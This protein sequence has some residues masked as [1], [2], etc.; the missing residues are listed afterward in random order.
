MV[1]GNI[2]R[3]SCTKRHKS[4]TQTLPSSVVVDFV[5]IANGFDESTSLAI[6]LSPHRSYA[7]AACSTLKTCDVQ[8]HLIRQIKVLGDCAAARLDGQL[9]LRTDVVFLREVLLAFCRS[10]DRRHSASAVC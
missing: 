7:L 8:S 5:A 10:A 9:Q 2:P 1:L 6:N 3:M 4:Q